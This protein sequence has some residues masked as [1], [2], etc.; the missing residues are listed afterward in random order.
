MKAK[1]LMITQL[2]CFAL[3]IMSA[4]GF[5]RELFP[6]ITFAISFFTLALCSIYI[7]QHQDELLKEIEDEAT[8]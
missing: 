8:E 1:K 7:S 5:L 2:F 6:S 4:E 3:I